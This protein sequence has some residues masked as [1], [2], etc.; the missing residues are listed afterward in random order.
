VTLESKRTLLARAREEQWL[1]VFEHDPVVPW[2]R[3]DRSQKKP[4]LLEDDWT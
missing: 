1:L 4:V 2:G 3:L